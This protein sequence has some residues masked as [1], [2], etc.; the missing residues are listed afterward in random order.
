MRSCDKGKTAFI[1]LLPSATHSIYRTNASQAAAIVAVGIYTPD[2][3]IRVA[4]WNAT[5]SLSLT[6]ELSVGGMA[7]LAKPIREGGT[8]GN[9]LLEAMRGAVSHFA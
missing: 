4:A 8:I 9:I 1:T 2:D 5:A 7:I 3:V 6:T